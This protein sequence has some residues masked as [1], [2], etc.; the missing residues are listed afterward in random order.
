MSLIVIFFFRDD[1]EEPD[2]GI[3]E[4]ELDP[5]R[6]KTGDI[7]HI[8]VEVVWKLNIRLMPWFFLVNCILIV[9]FC[10]NLEFLLPSSRYWSVHM[11]LDNLW[12]KIYQFSLPYIDFIVWIWHD[13]FLWDFPQLVSCTS[14]FFLLYSW[15]KLVCDQQRVIAIQPMQK[16]CAL[17]CWSSMSL[18]QMDKPELKWFETWSKS[19]K[20]KQSCNLSN[21][22]ILQFEHQQVLI[23]IEK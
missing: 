17:L 13:I 21:N 20:D 18:L 4:V 10:V 5:Q 1:N 8:C 19:D 3:I 22:P 11:W 15:C 23:T 7:W 14:C 16:L 6:N 12:D 9:C 2:S